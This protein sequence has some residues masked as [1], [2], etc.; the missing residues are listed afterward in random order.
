MAWLY[1]QE[2]VGRTWESLQLRLSRIR[3]RVGSPESDG[4]WQD[5]ASSRFAADELGECKKFRNRYTMMRYGIQHSKKDGLFLEFGTYKGRMLNFMAQEVCRHV[6]GGYVYGFDS[7]RGLPQ[8]WADT[9]EGSFALRNLPK[10]AW[11]TQLW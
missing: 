10:V 6:P 4:C 8:A 2:L 7:F 11:N 9:P 5:V 1:A 3:K